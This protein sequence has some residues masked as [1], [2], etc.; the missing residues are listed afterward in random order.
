MDLSVER[1]VEEVIYENAIVN[2]VLFEELI[3][4]KAKKNPT[5]AKIFQRKLKGIAKMLKYWA[6]G[7]GRPENG[8]FV[9]FDFS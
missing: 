3:K 9:S 4:E 8:S 5:E 6:S 1:Q 2:V 7:D